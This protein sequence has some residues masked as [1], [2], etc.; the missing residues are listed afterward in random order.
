MCCY[1]KPFLSKWISY[2][3]AFIFM[4]KEFLSFW[5]W[6]FISCWVY[7]LFIIMTTILFGVTFVNVF[8]KWSWLF[9]ILLNIFDWIWEKNI[10]VLSTQTCPTQYFWWIHRYMKVEIKSRKAL[11]SLISPK[12][13]ST[14]EYYDIHWSIRWQK[15]KKEKI[16]LAHETAGVLCK[17]L[18][19]ENTRFNT[20]ENTLYNTLSCLGRNSREWSMDWLEDFFSLTQHSLNWKKQ[21][22]QQIHAWLWCWLYFR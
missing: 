6:F 22:Q 20:K 10:Y 11:Y 9:L 19:K 16:R 15:R 8:G 13:K 4:S 2:F 12:L 5:E 17:H 14:K 1:E 21:Q 3:S 7:F 18:E